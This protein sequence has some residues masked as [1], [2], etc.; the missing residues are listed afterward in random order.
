MR[1]RAQKAYVSCL[2]LAK[3]GGRMAQGVPEVRFAAF[4][5]APVVGRL[6]L[7]FINSG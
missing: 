2:D 5:C 6:N 1:E 7:H 3:V 4:P